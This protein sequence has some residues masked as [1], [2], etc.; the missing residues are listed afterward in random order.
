MGVEDQWDA[1]VN[2]VGRGELQLKAAVCCRGGNTL[3]PSQ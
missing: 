3:N 2:N 1:K